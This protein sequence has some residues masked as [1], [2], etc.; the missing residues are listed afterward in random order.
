MSSGIAYPPPTYIPPLP[1]FNPLFFPQSFGTT[2]TSGGGGGF[3]NIFPNGLSSGNVITLNGGTGGGGGT[4]VERTIT[5]I[6]YL[7]FVD[8]ASTNPTAITGF[9]TLNGNTLEIGSANNSSGI[10]VNLQGTT[11]SA[12]GVAI[13]SGGNVSNDINNTFQSPATTQTFDTQSVVID[14]S[15]LSFPNGGNILWGNG[16]SILDFP[17][18]LPTTGG[19]SSGLAFAW[20]QQPSNGEV[21]MIAYGQ[22]GQGGFAFY[23]MTST[24]APTLIANLFPNGID[25]K[26][27]IIS[28]NTFTG[29]NYFNTGYIN[30]SNLTS[31]PSTLPLT[32]SQFLSVNNNPWFSPPNGGGVQ[33]ATTTTLTNYA[34][35]NSPAFN[36][37]PTA[38]NPTAG[39]SSNHLATTSFVASSFA[40]KNSPTFTGIPIAPTATFPNSSTQLA[41]TAFVSGNFAP[42]A[43]PLFSGIPTAPTA[44]STDNSTQLATTAFVQSVV[45]GSVGPIATLT[46]TLQFQNA[47]GGIQWGV[48][49]TA[50]PATAPY[51]SPPWGT[52]FTY[53]VYTI[54]PRG[55][56][57]ISPGMEITLNTNYGIATGSGTYQL[58]QNANNGSYNY[59]YVLSNTISNIGIN[60]DYVITATQD[61]SSFF[62]QMSSTVSYLTL[63]G[64]DIAIEIY[65]N[66]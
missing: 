18:T 55:S 47:T 14:N 31:F 29:D 4:G 10:N 39:D 23:S 64:I 32:Y 3:T 28:N 49:A 17:N 44:V 60:L 1:V 62:Y 58:T 25:F 65:P 19:G 13:A 54:V 48:I 34:L 15:A 8:S 61:G 7:D 41:T 52:T 38:P 37:T 16:T 66:Q 27:N 6:S 5:G 33:L 50:Q 24:T 63:A 53:K 2:T 11:L 22:G 30:L 57:T 9:I 12:N 20:N 40:P 42:L 35:L 26:K 59:A 56:L 45:G 51:T 46:S 36:G 43:S 21:D